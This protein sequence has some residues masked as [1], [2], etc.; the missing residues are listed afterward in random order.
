MNNPSRRVKSTT[1]ADS[2][3][4]L[5]EMSTIKTAEKHKRS[6]QHPF[7]DAP[8][9]AAAMMM[10]TTVATEA[11]MATVATVAVEAT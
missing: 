5:A 11:L 4:R 2:E 10:V 1:A 3:L 6:I 8:A 7:T 9:I